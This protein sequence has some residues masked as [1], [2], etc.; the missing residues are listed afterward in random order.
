V[1]LG[2]SRFPGGSMTLAAAD[3]LGA[4]QTV[5][6]SVWGGGGGAQD[7]LL[8][9]RYRLERYNLERLFLDFQIIEV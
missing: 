1:F 8:P 5:W 2:C 7:D 3:L 4:L 6:C 9:C